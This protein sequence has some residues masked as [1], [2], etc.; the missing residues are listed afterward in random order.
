L[1]K[2]YQIRYTSAFSKEF[3]KLDKTNQ[4][5]IARKILNLKIDPYIG[6]P[7]RGEW[8]GVY[9]LRS[10]TYRSL[11]EIKENEIY[12]LHVGHRKHAYE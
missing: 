5:K 10:G 11:Y 7:L 1:K 8:K 3:K 9:S 4:I 2:T 6:K 12:L